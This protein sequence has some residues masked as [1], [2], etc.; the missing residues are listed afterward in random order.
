V[1]PVDVVSVVHD[2]MES[3]RPAADAKAIQMSFACEAEGTVNADPHRLQQIVWNLLSNAI[4]FTPR[5]GR[6]AVAL[7]RGGDALQ[8]S[9]ED[10]GSGIAPDLLPRVFD[11]FLQADSSTTR[12]HGGLGLGLAI[13]RHLTELHGGSVS[14]ESAGPDQGATF[15]LWLP[16]GAAAL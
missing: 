13:V 3:M 10:T 4:K 8:L 16:L 6:V 15:R 2:M 7:L 12:Q 9:V 11:R 1:Q 14:A 5:G